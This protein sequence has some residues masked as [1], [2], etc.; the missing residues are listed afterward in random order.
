[1]CPQLSRVVAATKLQDPDGEGLT[2][3]KRLQT[4]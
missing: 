2:K 4:L 1:M 3:W